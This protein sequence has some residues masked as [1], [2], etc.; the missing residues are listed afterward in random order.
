M[1]LCC[2]FRRF[3][4]LLMLDALIFALCSGF[5][6]IGKA[7]LFSSAG[8]SKDDAVFL[9]V[10]MYHSV[11]DGPVQE[12]IVTPQ[13]FEN[14]LKWLKANGYSSVTAQQL[15]EY[16]CGSGE[17]PDKPVLITLDDGFYNNLSAVLPL[18]EK[19]DMQ[20]IVSVVGKY[21]DDYA[22]ADPHAERYSYL[23]WEDIS[24]LIDSGRVEIG[25]HTYDMHSLYSGRKGCSKLSSE[26]E[27]EYAQQLQNDI[28]LVQAEIK[29]HTGIL[30]IVFAY[31]FGCKSGESVPVLRRNGFLITLLCREA[32]NYITRSPDSLYDL[33]RYNRSGLYSTEEF[34][35][36]VMQ[37]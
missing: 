2:N 30:P 37:Q 25:C 36:K 28:G 1:Y 17:L 14:D 19:Y 6:F 3:M 29:E 33:F 9:P 18:L 35:E 11:Y 20:A 7:L 32:P 13:Q 16:A 10:I 26:T 23:T 15:A 12:Y 21:T 8:E 5:F 24:E 4:W 22:A 27:E 31:P 34:M